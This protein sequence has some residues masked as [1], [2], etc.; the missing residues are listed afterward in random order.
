M[1][2]FLRSQH[3]RSRSLWNRAILPHFQWQSRIPARRTF[4]WKFNGA[5]IP[6]ALGDS[7]VVTNVTAANEGQY[8]VVVSNG[9]GS[10][11]SA[12]AALMLD[13]DRD[14]LPDSWNFGNLTSQRAG[15]T[16][17]DPPASL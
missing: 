4:E 7:L 12:P 8:T 13:T 10:V 16:F 14:G 9:S 1:F 2:W 3:H 6:R 5:D 15:E 17:T 11:T